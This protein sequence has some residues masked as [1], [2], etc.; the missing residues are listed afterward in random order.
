MQQRPHCSHLRNMQVIGISILVGSSLPF[1]TTPCTTYTDAP[2]PDK[3]CSVIISYNHSASDIDALD[4][5][6]TLDFKATIDPSRPSCNAIDSPDSGSDTVDT[7]AG[8]ALCAGC[9]ATRA[10]QG[11][12]PPG[13]YMIITDLTGPG[14]LKTN[15]SVGILVDIGAAI[16]S[17]EVL[18]RFEVVSDTE[19]VADAAQASARL[20]QMLILTKVC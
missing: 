3:S 12:C 5:S 13:S 16:I 6:W 7:G 15:R 2:N 14:G 1:S 19:G 4:A 17:A 10:L 20:Q 8:G 18:A 9:P 11:Q